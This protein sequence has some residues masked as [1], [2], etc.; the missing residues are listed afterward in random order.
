MSRYL[1]PSKIGLLALIRLYSDGFVPSSATIAILSFLISYLLPVYRKSSEE[2]DS[3][4][5]DGFTVSIEKLQ[6]AT[7]SYTS[8]IPGRTLWDLLLK[9]L[10]TI[11]SLDGLHAFF[12]ELALLL[13][14]PFDKHADVSDHLEHPRPN[15]MLL[16]RNSPLG[17][18]VRRSQLE[19]TRLQF[20][21]GTSLWKSLIVY[22]RPT[23]PAWNRRNPG[24]GPLS[25][26]T[27]LQAECFD[28]DG[29]LLDLI[30]GG[31]SSKTGIFKDGNTS[32]DDMEK[33]LDYQ[34]SR[35]QSSSAPSR[36]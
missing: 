2:D 24:A 15:R 22:R 9:L 10:W 34:V 3:I 13:E 4:S 16:S 33:L 8:A 31:L 29:T 7:I 26:D 18:F 30:Y 11:N 19:F 5:Q 25:F 32:T 6:S 23:L 36:P 21:D 35:M 1:T 17:A 14:K 20:H 28:T 27:N 12:N